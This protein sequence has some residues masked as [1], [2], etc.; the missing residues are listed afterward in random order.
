MLAGAEKS[1]IRGNK[2]DANYKATQ[3]LKL[4]KVNSPD[5][6]RAKDI[7]FITKKNK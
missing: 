1:L 6:F 2:N 7:I 5:F 3:A 4:L